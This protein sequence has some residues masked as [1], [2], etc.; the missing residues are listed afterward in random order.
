MPRLNRRQ[1]SRRIGD[2][3][4]LPPARRYHLLTGRTNAVGYL[5]VPA[6]QTRDEFEDAWSDFGDQLTEEWIAKHPGT[7]PFAWWLCGD[8]QR[9]VI[10]DDPTMIAAT[11]NEKFCHTF[12]FLHSEAGNLYPVQEPQADYLARHGLLLPGEVKRIVPDLADEDDD[13]LDH[14]SD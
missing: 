10:A 3:S 7:R 11:L 8:H 6:Y 12:G 9:E 2:V 4:D 1:S 13:D 5:G 14:E